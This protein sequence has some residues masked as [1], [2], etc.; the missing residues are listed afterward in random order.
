M[1]VAIVL[2]ILPGL[3]W[4]RWV[5]SAPVVSCGFTRLGRVRR[6][7]GAALRQTESNF[8][9]QTDGK[10]DISPS[11]KDQRPATGR[12]HSFDSTIDRRCVHRLPVASSAIA[13]NVV[14]ALG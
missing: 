11:R 8:R 13:P 1:V 2:V 6:H 3:R 12:S 5:V 9:A 7:N 14:E 10:T 4:P